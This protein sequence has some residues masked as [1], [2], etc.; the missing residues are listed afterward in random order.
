ML[1]EL[2][3]NHRSDFEKKLQKEMHGKSGGVRQYL[4]IAAS[5]IVLFTMGYMI[6]LT[7]DTPQEKAQAPSASVSLEEFSPELKKIENYYL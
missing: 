1:R 3:H 5:V 2:S 6:S 7:Q 4:M